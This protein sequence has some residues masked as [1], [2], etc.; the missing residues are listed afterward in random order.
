MDV[1]TTSRSTSRSMRLSRFTLVVVLV[2]SLALLGACSSGSKK[3]GSTTGNN[4][5]R[6]ALA[7]SVRWRQCLARHGVKVKAPPAHAKFTRQQ[8][9]AALK[10]SKKLRLRFV[11]ALLKPPKGVVVARYRT[12]ANACLKP[13]AL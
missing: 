3:K 1:R 13:G 11:A 10:K 4:N 9:G 8:L 5:A 12:A 6:T 2:A 7:P